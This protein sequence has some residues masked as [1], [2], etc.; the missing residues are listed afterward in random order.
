M[1]PLPEKHRRSFEDLDANI[2]DNDIALEAR[3][4]DALAGEERLNAEH[5]A[6]PDGLFQGR[7]AEFPPFDITKRNDERWNR[8]TEAM[9]KERK[10]VSRRAV[11]VTHLLGKLPPYT[12]QGPRADAW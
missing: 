1:R 9:T 2:R 7:P 12:S 4:P 3:K 6:W 8:R 11:E 10:D 5:H